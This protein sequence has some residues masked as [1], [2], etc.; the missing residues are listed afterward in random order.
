MHPKRR[1]VLLFTLLI[2]RPDLRIRADR[3]ER[4][5]GPGEHHRPVERGGHEP[6]EFKPEGGDWKAIA[7]PAGGWRTQGYTCD[8]GT[9]RT[10]LTLP[11]YPGGDRVRLAFDAINF[12]A[13]ISAGRDEASLHP[14]AEHIDGWVPVNAD[15]TPLAAPGEKL[16]VQVEVAGRKKA[17]GQRQIHRAR[18]SLVVSRVGGGHPARRPAGNPARRAR[19]DVFVRTALGPDVLNAQVTLANDTDAPPWS[20][21][22]PPSSRQTAR[23]FEYPKIAEVT[24][25]LPANDHPHGRSSG[26]SRGPPARKVTGGQT[27]RT[28]PAF[29]RNSIV[30]CWRS[31]SMDARCN[32]T[33]NA[34]VSGSSRPW[35]IITS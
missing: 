3:R 21:W 12:G 30:S 35:A 13:K 23:H 14:V 4:W 10:T 26:T 19:G 16:L 8:A 25:D 32:A 20:R 27:C 15:L 33:P 18:G 22:R 28:S 9:Y 17:D 1:L 5:R 2:L 34:S 29:K 6:W 11:T 24:C 31:R 7:V